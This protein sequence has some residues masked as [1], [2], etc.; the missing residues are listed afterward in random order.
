[1]ADQRQAFTGPCM[2]EDDTKSFQCIPYGYHGAHDDL[3]PRGCSI[4]E[5]TS[6][7]VYEVIHPETG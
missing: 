6:S 7:G 1:M 2:I 5:K 4:L 3:M